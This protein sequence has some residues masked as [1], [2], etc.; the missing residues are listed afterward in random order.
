MLTRLTKAQ[1]VTIPAEFRRKLAL[2]E[3]RLLEVQLNGRKDAIV[4]RPV[5]TK[6]LTELFKEAD[7]IK[8]KTAK[9]VEELMKDYERENMLH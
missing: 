8:R 9:T 3:G 7:K 2:K 4:I 1:Q 6:S 5:S